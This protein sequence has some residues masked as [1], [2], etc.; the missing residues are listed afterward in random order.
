MPTPH[1]LT[2]M[3]GSLLIDTDKKKADFETLKKAAEDTEA[4]FKI[5]EIAMK[6]AK[7]EF[8]AFITANTMST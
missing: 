6:K 8:G 7:D 4:A 3:S 1:P 2:A 5:A